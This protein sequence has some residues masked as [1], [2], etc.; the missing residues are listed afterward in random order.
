MIATAEGAETEGLETATRAESKQL[1]ER[2]RRA[3]VV[4]RASQQA[5]ALREQRAKQSDAKWNACR[6]NAV[7]CTACNEPHVLLRSAANCVRSRTRFSGRTARG[8]EAESSGRR[9]RTSGSELGIAEGEQLSQ[10]AP[11]AGIAD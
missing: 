9:L 10:R 7:R 11:L 1:S 4:E 2:A 3:T 6:G 8:G 5:S